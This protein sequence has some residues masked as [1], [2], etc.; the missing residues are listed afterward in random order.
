VNVVSPRWATPLSREFDY[1]GND[2][3]LGRLSFV[4]AIIFNAN[5]VDWV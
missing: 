4:D 3:L 1:S 5:G 2:G